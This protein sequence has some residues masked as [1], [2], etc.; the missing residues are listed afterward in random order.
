MKKLTSTLML[1]LSANCYAK[2]CIVSNENVN[3]ASAEQ[4]VHLSAEK[5]IRKKN[6]SFVISLPSKLNGAILNSATIGLI[7]IATSIED[8]EFMVQL[9]SYKENNVHKVWFIMPKNSLDNLYL[10]VDYGGDCEDTYLFLVND[11][12]QSV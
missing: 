1:M 10:S 8:L 12:K 6:T 2:S 9:R 5:T 7:K 3:K 11:I 4:I